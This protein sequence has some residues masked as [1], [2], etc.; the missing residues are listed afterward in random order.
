[1]KAFL[2][3]WYGIECTK[4]GLAA[5][6]MVR[7]IVRPPGW[8]ATQHGI[9]QWKH[10]YVRDTGGYPAPDTALDEWLLLICSNCGYCTEME[11]ADS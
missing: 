5:P 8:D 10:D 2:R 9:D 6:P 11:T 4:C 7:H 3:A 1:M